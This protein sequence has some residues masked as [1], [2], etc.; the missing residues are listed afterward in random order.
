MATG[1]FN[2][3]T[4]RRG[5]EAEYQ[6]LYGHVQPDGAILAAAVRVSARAATGTPTARSGAPREQRNVDRP[7]SLR[8]VWRETRG[9]LETVVLDGR[10]LRPATGWAG[11]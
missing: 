6:R 9:W 1:S 11:R 2:L 4:A 3:N 10:R 5:F 7:D 8:P